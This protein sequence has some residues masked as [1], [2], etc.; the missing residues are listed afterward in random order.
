MEVAQNHRKKI[1]AYGHFSNSWFLCPKV[2]QEDLQLHQSAG[3]QG[4]CTTGS[5]L[6]KPGFMHVCVCKSLVI[7]TMNSAFL[8]DTR[9][10]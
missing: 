5:G 3:A 8:Q 6:L 7:H 9:W 2:L 10:Y 4:Y 1:I